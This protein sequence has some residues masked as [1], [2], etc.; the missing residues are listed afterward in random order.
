MQKLLGAVLM[1]ASLLGAMAQVN[2]E[3]VLDQE[4]FLRSESL[5]LRI[6][7][8]NFSGQTLKMAEQPDWL[9]FHIDDD[10]SR[11]L[12]RKG[13]LPAMKPFEIESSKTVSLRADLMPQFDL[14]RIGRYRISARVQ[15]PQLE[16]EIV[17]D[18]KKFDIISGTDIWKREFGVPGHTPP[19]VRLYTL[20]VANL[21]KGNQIYVRITDS[22]GARVFRVFPLGPV[23]SFSANTIEAQLDASNNLHVLFQNYKDTFVYSVVA[24]DG[25]QIIRQLHEIAGDS[26]PHIRTEDGNRILVVGGQRRILLSDLPPPHVANT[27]EVLGRK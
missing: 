4:Q 5:P 19:E 13:D 22:T 21:Q 7:I 3:V 20:Q 25:E 15:F 9:V 6:R 12:L 14:S 18:Q 23:M 24:P 1:A 17:T 26:R 8:S 16:K 2:V 10:E 11:A 27:N